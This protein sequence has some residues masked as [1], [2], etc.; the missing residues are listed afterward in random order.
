MPKFLLVLGHAKSGDL[1]Y[2]LLTSRENGRSRAGCDHGPP[3]ASYFL[4]RLDGDMHEPTWVTLNVADDLDSAEI[5]TLIGAGIVSTHCKVA[6]TLLCAILDCAARS[7][8]ATQAQIEAMRD[9][10]AALNC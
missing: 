10:R 2:R 1:I 8:D 4:D 9:T 5:L 6:K 3:Y 7:D